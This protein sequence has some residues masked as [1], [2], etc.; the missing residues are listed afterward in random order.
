M[1]RQPPEPI[2]AGGQDSFVDV[3]TNL[4]GILIVLVLI[5]GVRVKPAWRLSQSAEARLGSAD[6]AAKLADDAKSAAEVKAA[7]AKA[8]AAKAAKDDLAKL[9]AIADSVEHDVRQVGVQIAVVDRELAARA[10]ERQQVATLIAAAEHEIGARRSKLDGAAQKEVDLKHV[11]DQLES[12]VQISQAELQRARAA[13]PPVA[14][15]RHY[16]TPISRTVFGQEVHFRLSEHR[17]AYL[18]M[19]EL[20]ERA[21]SELRGAGG[22]SP[23]DITDQ[24]HVVGPYGGFNME[25][26]MAMEPGPDRGEYRLSLQQANFLPTPG[27]VGETTDDALRPD[28][29]FRRRINALDHQLTTITIWVYPESFPDFRRINDDL[30]RL[31]F[32]VAARPMPVGIPVGVSNHGSHSSAQ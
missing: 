25:F 14:E 3:V 16:M 31:G 9:Q 17:I 20:L 26:T 12:D 21:K 11:A 6:S 8:T 30:Y 4:V 19:D 1:R 28:S 32:A 13:P 22:S 15:L 18:P 5:V 7:A 23:S 2:E 10:L 29:E 24:V 27:Q